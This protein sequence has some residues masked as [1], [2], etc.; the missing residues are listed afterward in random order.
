MS[1]RVP[2]PDWLPECMREQVRQKLGQ[3]AVKA[4]KRPKYG[5]R[6]RGSSLSSEKIIKRVA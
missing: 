3:T 1:I 6:K 5:N 2:S 4:P